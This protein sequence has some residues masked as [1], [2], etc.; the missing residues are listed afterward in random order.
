MKKLNLLLTS[1]GNLA[2]PMVANEA[3]KHF[4]CKITGLDIRDDAH[5]LYFCDEKRIT[6]RSSDPGYGQEISSIYKELDG[7]LLI[8]LSTTDQEFFSSRMNTFRQ[9]QLIVVCSDENAVSLANHKTKLFRHL[10]SFI[11][12]IPQFIEINS[13]MDVESMIAGFEGKPFVIK[14]AKG[15][16]GQGSFIVAGSREEL[17]PNDR[18]F[19]LPKGEW[20]SRVEKIKSDEERFIMEYLP[21][22][23][24]SVDCLSLSGDLFY[25]VVRK[26][27]KTQGGM[28]LVSEVIMDEEIQLLVKEI[29]SNLKFSYINNIQ[30]K[31]DANN[32]LKLIEIN[33]RIPGTLQLSIDAGAPFIR[34][35]INLALGKEPMRDPPIKTGMKYYR[36][37]SG[38]AVE[39]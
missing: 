38:I 24:F 12:F 22:D 37:W 27:L 8:P 1:V 18:Q 25:C 31:R 30:F 10:S 15:T 11:N 9:D 14:Q 33:P 32:H 39:P 23:E 2:M 36:Y 35:M 7:D 5:G 6:K 26:R 28:A 20:I 16:G 29:I 13:E 4:D 3:R 17:N 34:D 19:F 21:G